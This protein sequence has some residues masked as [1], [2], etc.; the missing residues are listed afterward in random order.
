MS[1]FHPQRVPFK[2]ILFWLREGLALSIAKPLSIVAVIALYFALGNFQAAS[3]DIM[4][5]VVFLSTSFLLA[6]ICIF[7][8]AIDKGR[9]LF[10]N[11]KA[12]PFSM[13]VNVLLVGVIPLGIDAFFEFLAALE[14]LPRPEPIKPPDVIEK[15]AGIDFGGY[16][17]AAGPWMLLMIP[18]IS[19]AGLSFIH[20]LKQSFLAVLINLFIFP[21]VFIIPFISLL[22]SMISEYLV[23]PWIAIFGCAQY[24]AYRHIWLNK[25]ENSYKPMKAQSISVLAK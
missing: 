9:N 16:C 6:I 1:E 10:D 15:N 8:E 22:I 11:L 24:V 18:L 21:L 25:L 19:N 7:A 12:K 23:F 14:I 5:R 2:S 13:W 20:A 3:P 17:I 4:G